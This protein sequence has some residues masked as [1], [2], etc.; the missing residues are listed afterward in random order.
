MEDF[1]HEFRC[2]INILKPKEKKYHPIIT[3]AM[4]A[5]LV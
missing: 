5:Q 3:R 4:L 1:K 2:Q